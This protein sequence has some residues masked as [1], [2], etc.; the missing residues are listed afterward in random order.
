MHK[1]W[2]WHRAGIIGL[3][4]RNHY[5]EYAK[6]SNGKSGQRARTDGPHKRK[7]RNLRRIK[8]KSWKSQAL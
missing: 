1:T 6:G 7:D 5:D 3:G 8:R 4:F 2:V